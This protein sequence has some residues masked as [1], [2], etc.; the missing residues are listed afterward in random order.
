MLSVVQAM[1][2]LW[3][4]IPRTLSTNGKERV[5]EGPPECI[6]YQNIEYCAETC[7]DEDSSWNTYK[8]AQKPEWMQSCEELYSTYADAPTAIR[9]QDTEYSVSDMQYQQLVSF[10][11]LKTDIGDLVR[12]EQPKPGDERKRLWRADD[13]DRQVYDASPRQASG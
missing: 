13:W 10:Q 9:Y 11:L 4:W 8:W 7:V 6:I 3:T 2:F 1:V 5:A 12:R